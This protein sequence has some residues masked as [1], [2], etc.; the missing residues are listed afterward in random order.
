[1]ANNPII[2]VNEYGGVYEHGRA[3]T[4]AHWVS[5]IIRYEKIV[6]EHGSCTIRHLA[7]SCGISRQS[8]HKAIDYYKIG[9]I[10]PPIL[11]QGVWASRSGVLLWIE[12]GASC[13]YLR[14][15]C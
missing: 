8:S 11:P 13:I 2:N 12:G 1:M 9:V 3:W 14:I 6:R 4:K 7:Q 10:V 15:I 5:I